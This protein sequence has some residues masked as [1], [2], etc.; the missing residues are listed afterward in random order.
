MKF[1]QFLLGVVLLS[2]AALLAGTFSQNFEGLSNNTPDVAI[3]VVGNINGTNA[4]GG[5]VI[6]NKK[7]ANN[8]GTYNVGVIKTGVGSGGTT[9]LRLAEKVTANCT[10][11]MIVPVLDGTTA[12]V[13]EFTV[14]LDL[15]L[16]KSSAAAVPAD[17]FN[18]SF[19]SSGS[20]P[21]SGV[22]GAGGHGSPLGL[23]V[24]FD[25]YQNSTSDPRSIEIFA[26]GLTVGNFLASS[27]TGGNFTYD[28]TF[29]H[30][31]LHW[32]VNNG[33]DLTYN[34]Q[35]I[36]TDLPTPGFVPQPNA[37]FALNSATGGAFQDTYVDNISI[38]TA[39]TSP[40]VTISTSDV[41]IEE[42][43]ADN[44]DG[45]EDED[46]DKP[47]WIE[48][49]NGTATPKTITGWFL[50]D[51]PLVLNKWPCPALTIPAFGYQLFFASGK[52]K[53]TNVRPHTNF[54]LPKAGGT[55][56][57]TAADG[58]TVIDQLSYG[59]Q[60]EDASYGRLGV[61]Q[62]L[63]F[64]E[65]PT[66]G[67]RNL[68][69][70]A[71]N[72]RPSP[73]VFD[74]PSG[75]IT[76]AT[77]LN[78]SLP[79]DAPVGSVIRYT[80]NTGDPLE[81]SPVFTLGTPLSITTGTTVRAK[82]F[83]PNA[84]PSRTGNCSFI[85][86]GTG[87][88]NNVGNNYNGSGAAF[89]SS[90]PVIVLDSFVRNVDGF[91]N[92]L[93][94][95]P[96][97]FTQAAVYD[98]NPSTSRASLSAA[99]TL[100]SRAGTHVR[101]QSS[102]GQPERPY[103]LE[104]WREN[105]DVDENHELL[106]FPADSDWVLMTLYLDKSMMRNYLMQQLMLAANGPGSGVRCRFVEVFFNQVD[107]T[108]DYS[109]YR[110]VYLLMERVGRGK[111]RVNIAK[112]NDSMSAPS[113]T[114]GGYILK[115]DKTP[116]DSPFSPTSVA[117]IPGSSRVY[118]VFD[119]EPPTAVQLTAIKG[120][121]DQMT[122]A[123]A[124][125][126]YNNPTSA[127]YYGKW[128]DERSFIDKTLWY[129]LCK[130][131]DAYTFSYYF[132]KDRN[133]P[134]TAFPFWD[135]D[136]GLGNSNYGTSNATF[137]FKWWVVGGNYT[138]YTRLDDDAEFNDRYWN[139]W[140]ALRRSLFAKDSLFA[141]I[142][143]VYTELAEGSAADITNTTATSL[144]VPIARHFRKYPILGTNS[145][146]G[147]QTGQLTRTTW[148][149][150]VNALKTWLSERLDWIDSAPATTS[151]TVLSA[152]LRP[153]EMF[154]GTT[155]VTQFGGNVPAGYPFKLGNPN[156]AGGTAYYTIDGPDPRQTGGALDPSA[157]TAVTASVSST[158]IMSNAQAWKWLLPAA[159]PANDT[160]GAPWTAEA[161]LDTSWA[162]G[163][164]PLGYGEATGLTTNISP[165][166]PNYLNALNAAGTGE[167]GAAYFRTT[168]TASGTASLT[169]AMVEIM[170]DDGA[171]IYL[172]GVE[173]GRCNYPL[174]PTSPSYGQEALGPVD[175]G[176]NYSPLETMFIQV[177][178]DQRK[179][180]DGVNTL[181]VEVHQA[182]YAFPPNPANLYP[183]NDFSDLR[184]DLR[185]V[186]L[187]A[188]GAGSSYS[189]NTAGT[190]VVRTRIKSGTTWS[191]LTEAVF[192][193]GGTAPV[194][195]ELVVS[196]LHYHPADPTATE[197]GLGFN[198]ENDFEFIELMNISNHPL[199]LSAV[200]I[201]GAVTYNFGTSSPSARYLV[202]GGR[203]VVAENLAAFASR[204]VGGAA[205]VV[206][207]A[208]AGNFANSAEE[209]IINNGAVELLKFTYV[210]SAPW[211]TQADG[212]G[213]CL[214]LNLPMTNP[215]H[216]NPMS[217]RPSFAVNGAPGS[218]DATPFT[219]VWNAD[220]DGDGLTDGVAYATGV[221]VGG[222]PPITSATESLIVSPSTNSEN[223][224]VIRCLRKLNTDAVVQPEWCQDL[225]SWTTSGLVY[226]GVETDPVEVPAGYAV[227]KFRSESPIS[228]A[229]TRQ[230][231]RTRVTGY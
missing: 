63:G 62:S 20:T 51:D 55:V 112:L 68:G 197:L 4:T 184:F 28:Q 134:L 228:S 116:Y 103:G 198:K 165:V 132:S 124:A 13:A 206:A 75:V 71:L 169:G 2:P 36:F 185:V 49:Y 26:D 179:L 30:V 153:T 22:G 123:L 125:T 99:P 142:E 72:F 15:L 149:A 226:E 143:A 90:L 126:D 201:D 173:I 87:A 70:Q 192:V 64:L 159:A 133:G 82:V 5:T 31:V 202:P 94:A 147:G 52:N 189:L 88:T 109:D 17:G 84:L 137:G 140:T 160:N 175:P 155:G 23:I 145:F 24:N 27:L 219:G 33:L 144:Q 190:H 181:A 57:L 180:K 207:G 98:I 186:G 65:T 218:S 110:G 208:F 211:P 43:L 74:K 14:E 213:P 182:L 114:N 220:S 41:V 39:L 111:D 225:N 76:A 48:L 29:R 150:E 214:V 25:T 47:D 204:L 146:T 40:P 96:Y 230:F 217:W 141:R 215:D 12:Q 46:L 148:R 92:P 164:A 97:R 221:T 115:N 183:R 212:D 80:L 170:A 16:D 85:M 227:L 130:E 118:D 9:A 78:I 18:I 121:F 161:F 210:D 38:T 34:G 86:L 195:G 50:S 194:P 6:S 105:E 53:F 172:N 73:P 163:T 83:A 174:S 156:P 89:S 120:W 129:E 108:L 102:S 7:E 101:G 69:R 205:P 35:V 209:I 54:T 21:L 66:P 203:V 77:T 79:V 81:T 107:T 19:G 139:R 222:L 44:A 154:N 231:I 117:A 177:P 157:L 166:A 162:S 178:F 199:D 193:V 187:T 106:G 122:Q 191:P 100:L 136:R 127:N 104:F 37:N 223:F 200:Q 216:N 151:T 131:V 229:T 113:L 1:P 168:F 67:T 3:N 171:V 128:L 32:D 45:K 8:V 60:K 158:T 188:S 56:Y 95:R 224:L 11:A 119:P 93:G 138:Y 10:A 91:T 42:I 167:P 196:Q 61:A 152:R 176:N 59:A 135:V 58:A